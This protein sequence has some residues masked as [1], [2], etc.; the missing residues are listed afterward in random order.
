LTQVDAVGPDGDAHDERNGMTETLGTPGAPLGGGSPTSGATATG[1][2]STRDVAK[3]EAKGVAQDAVQGGRQTAETAKQQAGEVAGEAKNQAKDLLD[4]T[5]Q[6]IASQGTQQQQRAASGLRSVADEIT[7]MIN[8]QGGTG[9][10]ASDLARQLSQRVQTAADWLEHREPRDLFDEVQRFARRRPGTF[11][12]AAG[13]LGF[14]GGRLT[15]GAVDEARDSGSDSGT[16]RSGSYTSDY[17]GSY[18]GTGY[19]ETG[20]ADT[21]YGDTGYGQVSSAQGTTIPATTT[22]AAA[23]VGSEAGSSYDY[24]EP[25]GSGGLTSTTESASRTSPHGDATASFSP[26]APMT[27]RGG[28]PSESALIEDPAGEDRFGGR[29]SEDPV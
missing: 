28:T 16:Y 25:A 4:Q 15:R 5:R 23:G 29:G 24:A 11:L 6:E 20:Y 17:R 27:A 26:T 2:D 13:A 19:V 21:G 12:A 3:E 8:G 14:L 1:S 18:G 9:G 7:S 10:V 22:G